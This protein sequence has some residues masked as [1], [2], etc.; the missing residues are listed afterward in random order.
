MFGIF[1]K[2]PDVRRMFDDGKWQVAQG[3]Y[4][5]NPI[6]VRYNGALRQFVGESDHTLKI[7]FAI[8]LNTPSE[9]GLPPAVENQELQLVEGKILD[10]VR[11]RTSVV[12]AL[13]ITTG[14]L[15][16]YVFYT[17]RDINV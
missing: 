8:P 16:E 3:E 13:A 17:R 6:I 12:Q 11:S 10:A 5:G 1:G 4:D 2:K 7:A 14:T 15:K 9:N